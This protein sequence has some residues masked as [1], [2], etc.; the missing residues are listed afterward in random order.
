MKSRNGVR[1][2]Y[3]SDRVLQ[4][5]KDKKVLRDSYELE[6]AAVRHQ[7]RRMLEDID[8]SS[9]WSTEMVNCLSD[10]TLQTRNSFKYPSREIKKKLNIDFKYHYLRH[11]YGTMM[12]E[13]NTPQHLLCNQLGHGSIRV[14]QEYYLAVTKNGVD[15]IKENINKL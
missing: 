4:H 5:L 7:K 9:I 6:K 10:G 14:T 2:V 3:L 15:L 12:A 1:T 8:G 13:L 11:T